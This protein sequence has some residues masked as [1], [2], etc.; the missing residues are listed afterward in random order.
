MGADVSYGRHTYGQVHVVGKIGKITVGNFCSIA[1]DVKIIT[2]GHRTDRVSTYPFGAHGL[3]PVFDHAP[4]GHPK[5]YG[6][7]VIG[8]DVWIGDGVTILGGIIIGNGAVIGA[9]AVVSEAVPHFSVMV[10]NPAR[11]THIRF[12]HWAVVELLKIAWWNWPDEKIS[13]N[14][15]LICSEN[16]EEFVKLHG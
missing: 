15:H 16:V 10:G 8:N 14:L 1:S 2:V 12:N 13:E 4:A 5:Y 7:T 9:G 3:D 11:R 6:D